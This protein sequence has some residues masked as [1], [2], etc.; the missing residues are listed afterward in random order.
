MDQRDKQLES[1]IRQAEWLVEGDYPYLV[2]VS[3]TE[4][5]SPLVDEIKRL[6][7]ANAAMQAF[8]DAC[9]DY[10]Q[11]SESALLIGVPP[12]TEKAYTARR[13]KLR[14]AAHWAMHTYL[15]QREDG[16]G[17]RNVD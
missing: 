16:G 6:Q 17:G 9:I 3:A 2:K 4:V 14:N 10:L 13:L 8:V 11:H 7:A 15:Q 12:L 5:L 1:A